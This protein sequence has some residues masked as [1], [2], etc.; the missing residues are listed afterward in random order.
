MQF[1]GLLE[2]LSDDSASIETRNGDGSFV[3][4]DTDLQLVQ[5]ANNGQRMAGRKRD[6]ST[7][8]S[9]KTQ[10]K[11][12]MQEIKAPKKSF[13]RRSS[14]EALSDFVGLLGALSC[15]VWIVYSSGSLKLPKPKDFDAPLASFSEARALL[16]V[17]EITGIGSHD[18]G[19]M[20]LEYVTFVSIF[21]LWVTV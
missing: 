6:S 20:L 11:K 4:L 19:S 21:F 15:F 18:F 7:A 16:A 1:F 8:T 14:F 3:S 10:E 9:K 12:G 2:L 5:G 17:K 13:K